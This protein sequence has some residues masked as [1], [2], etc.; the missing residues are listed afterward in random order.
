VN[1]L[2][3]KDLRYLSEKYNLTGKR[4]KS[5]LVAAELKVSEW[6]L[7]NKKMHF[8]LKNLVKTLKDSKIMTLY[9][10]L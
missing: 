5:D 2:E 9:W 6:N 4:H 10:H 1:L 3:K 8:A 7:F